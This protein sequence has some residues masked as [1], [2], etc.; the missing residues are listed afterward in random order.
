MTK[1]LPPSAWGLTPAQRIERLEGYAATARKGH[2]NSKMYKVQL[3]RY[4]KEIEE[5]RNENMPR[6]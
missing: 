2:K 5:I 6:L 3:P 4:P 1:F